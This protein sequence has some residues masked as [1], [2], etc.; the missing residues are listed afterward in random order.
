MT[1][2]RGPTV[3]AVAPLLVLS[4]TIA[5]VQLR[6]Q[7]L[8]TGAGPEATPSVS[9]P[10]AEPTPLVV[11]TPTPTPVATPV[12]T[13]CPTL[14]GIRVTVFATQPEK[15]RVVLDATPLSDQCSAF[16]G[17]LVC[18]LGPAGSEA[19]AQCEAARI[20]AE[21]PEW[22]I[23]PYGQGTV[24]ALP[25]SGYLA[26]VVGRGLVIACSRVQPGVCANIEIR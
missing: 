19:R 21:G 13:S 2:R 10:K 7:P 26:A 16:P 14:L 15:D 6:E 25:G 11:A 17:R 9:A 18:P 20:G 4:A 24:E 8:P 23:E 1:Q 5:C 3:R 22:T 12:A